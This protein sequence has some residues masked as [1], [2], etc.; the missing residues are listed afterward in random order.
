[1]LLVK[2]VS[3]EPCYWQVKEWETA[4]RKYVSAKISVHIIVKQKQEAHHICKQETLHYCT[5]VCGKWLIIYCIVITKGC[6]GVINT[7][8]LIVLAS[9][10]SPDEAVGVVAAG[11]A[12]S[13]CSRSSGE[14]TVQ[15]LYFF[16]VSSSR[17]N[18][19]MCITY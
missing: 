19:Y 4:N 15:K 14:L 1:V 17:T 8:V 2:K 13:V 18:V 5:K 3:L 12:G 11:P 10:L 7:Y 16:E 9:I 6:N